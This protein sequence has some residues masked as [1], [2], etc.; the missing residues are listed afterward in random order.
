MH[1]LCYT[2]LDR[3]TAHTLTTCDREQH[4]RHVNNSR[5]AFDE[6]IIIIKKNSEQKKKPI[7]TIKKNKPKA[8]FD[9]L[10]A[11][12]YFD[13]VYFSS[14]SIQSSHCN[15]CISFFFLHVICLIALISK[16]YTLFFSCCF[17]IFYV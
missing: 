6:I 4:Q 11:T 17:T 8:I 9:E 14:V 1:S 3:H 7:A 13:F 10:D 12:L 15:I 16:D 5:R 2:I